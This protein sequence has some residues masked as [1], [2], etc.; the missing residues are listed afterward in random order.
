MS[1][2]E[3]DTA[4]ERVF[5]LHRALTVKQMGTIQMRE[6]HDRLTGWQFDLDPDKKPFTAGT[7]KLDREDFETALTMFYEECGWDPKTGAPTKETL[8]RLGLKYVAD[9]LEV[10]GLLPA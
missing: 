1:E 5:T 8:V 3:L 4:A 2:E 10:M 6:Q 9:E 7:I